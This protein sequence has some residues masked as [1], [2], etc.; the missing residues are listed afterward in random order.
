MVHAAFVRS[1]LA[2]ARITEIDAATAREAPGVLAVITG[3]EMAAL[4]T[5]GGYGIAGLF[6]VDKPDYCALA[7]DKV[8]HVGDPVAVVVAQTRAL[9]ED[10]CELVEVDYDDLPAV[11]TIDQALDP[12]S[13]PIFEDLGSN[14]ILPPS[15]KVFGDVEAA[16][17][18]A[19]RI[20]RARI[21]QHR[22]QNV[23]MECRGIVASYDPT[24]Q[25]FLIWSA[26]QGVQPARQ[27]LAARLGV[28]V[29]KVRVRAG[30]IGGSFGLKT[31]SSREDVA[32]AVAAKVLRRPVKWCE[33]RFEHMCSAGQARDER[34]DIEAAVM[35]DGEILGLRA[36][37]VVDSGSYPGMGAMVSGLAMEMLPNAYKIGAL[38]FT[39]SAVVTNKA[40]Y[41]AYRGPW[42]SETFVRERLID[43]VALEL[44]KD[45]LEIRRRNVVGQDDHDA[46]MVTGRTL[47]GV[48]NRESIERAAQ[49]IDVPAFR[50]RQ[51]RARE[52]HRYLGL[53]F[54]SFIEPAPGPR[55]TPDEP[56]GVMGPEPMRMALADDG[57]LLVYTGQMPHGQSHQTTL[58][59]VAADEFG[60]AF[61]QVEV[62][63]GDTDV[64][65]SSL[66]G[67]SLSA[68]M[69]GGAAVV[70]ARA[71][72]AKVIAVAELLLEASAEDLEIVD[73]A[74]AVR[75][76]SSSAL[77]LA[78]LVASAR[79]PGRLP[80]D[81]DTTFEASE[82]YD[83]GAGGWSGGTHA[84]IVE[85]DL[86]TG[87]VSFERYVV[88]ED[89][90]DIINP[91]VVDGQIRGGV[92][93]G[94]GAVL[95]E[96]SAYDEDG[97][98]LSATFM[99][100]LLPTALS[101]PF[102]EIEHLPATRTD[103]IV[104]F[105]G[106][107]EGGLIVS[108]PTV[109][110]AIED[111]LAPFGARIYEEYCPP[112]RLLELAGVIPTA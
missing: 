48:T 57:H 54:A 43:L 51:A 45:P 92:A 64:V 91:A 66:T 73:G 63:V 27:G 104:N 30:D 72:R 41:V 16:F 59:Q 21:S 67:G 42:A 97:Q 52:Q 25:D 5:P 19:D 56:L 94:I 101:I 106:V 35:D 80:D 10:A 4:V 96:R 36:D 46:V 74:I 77:P 6:G 33:D 13:S 107:G 20:V 58:A 29:E 28:P 99:D 3:E 100:Y 102:I 50:R 37:M 15:T 23:P 31:G 110:N 75:G 22:Y 68:T 60:V 12:A 34:Y 82:T 112:S 108:T 40:T 84:A 61:D 87:L 95:L 109:C 55:R 7:N 1:P 44:G 78:E 71:L 39:A 105:R 81:V 89:C 90:G 8:R 26:N 69:A 11:V 79:A 93:Q 47:A 86:T 76:I 88:V 18:R 38:S 83:G 32:V 9:A 24:S 49:L 62:V 103:E 2:H 65:P 111:A 70:S 85:V 17:A 98:F 53:G 14:V